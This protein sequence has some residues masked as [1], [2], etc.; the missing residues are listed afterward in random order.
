MNK[1]WIIRI[2][3]IVI[4]FSYMGYTKLISN[5][6]A[7]RGTSA[8]AGIGLFIELTDKSGEARSYRLN[9]PVSVDRRV[10]FTPEI[11]AANSFHITLP[12]RKTYEVPG[13]FTGNVDRGGVCNVEIISSAAHNT[14]HIETSAHILSYDT[15]PMTIDQIPVKNLS[16][17]LY[18]I[19][20]SSISAEPGKAVE[21]IDI[22]RKLLQIELP[23]SMLAIKTQGSVLPEDYDFSGKDFIYLAPEAAKAIND[24]RIMEKRID[25]L[26]LDLPSID[27]ENDEG[28]LLAHRYY[29]GL[30]ESGHTGTGTEKRTLIELA[31]FSGLEEGYYYAAIT[32]P[33][34]QTNAMTTG[35]FLWKLD[36]F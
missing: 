2:V 23:V 18:L 8:D 24:F 33:R 7:R 17:L 36:D 10:L 22:E 5:R 15:D 9:E 25:C 11:K 3:V 32:P 29:F 31:Y 26:L 4:V 20:L 14:T 28:K 6:P 12:S 1:R 34:F 19:D 27:R 13:Q 21:W 16:G 35:I 30:P